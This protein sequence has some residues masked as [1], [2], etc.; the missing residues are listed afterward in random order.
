MPARV[1]GSAFATDG[2]RAFGTHG[3]VPDDDKR[4]GGLNRAQCARDRTGAMLEPPCF[5]WVHYEARG[6]GEPGT[7]LMLILAL[8]HKPE[9]P[10]SVIAFGT[11]VLTQGV[12]D[13]TLDKCW[14]ATAMKQEKNNKAA[15]NRMQ[16]MEMILS[17]DWVHQAALKDI[18]LSAVVTH[19]S[20]ERSRLAQPL[21]SLPP[22]GA[23]LP[24]PPQPPP[25][26]GPNDP[27]CIGVAG[28]TRRGHIGGDAHEDVRPSQ[29]AEVP[30]DRD[31]EGGLDDGRHP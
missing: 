5:G 29:S 23:P 3:L 10:S 18:E 19:S 16:P 15:L 31:P 28:Q 9:H 24:P 12:E 14:K 26:S 25:P 1:P 27:C 21:V 22:A 17:L 7:D 20:A 30:R 8:L 13:A 2:V 11:W 4:F 6:T